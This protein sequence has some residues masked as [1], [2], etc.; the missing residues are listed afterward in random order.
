MG[1]NL[2]QILIGVIAPIAAS[3][4]AAAFGWLKVVI[5][6]GKRELDERVDRAADRAVRAIEDWA[7]SAPDLPNGLAQFQAAVEVLSSEFIKL[8]KAEAERRIRAAYRRMKESSK[9]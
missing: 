2:V 6:I 3:A 5:G 9:S 7:A 8:T 4:V 1:E